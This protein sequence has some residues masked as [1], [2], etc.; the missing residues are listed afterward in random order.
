MRMAQTVERSLKQA[1]CDFDIVAHP[2]SATSLESARVASVPAERVAK[3]VILDDR[4]GN[5]IMAVLPA[6][7]HL[8]LSK[9]QS[10]GNWQLTRESGLPHLFG[11]CERGAIPALGEAYGMKMLLDPTLTRQGDIYLEAGNH[12][13]LVHM[14]M[15]EYLKLVPHAEVREVCH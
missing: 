9:I 13:Y 6:N 14:K 8:D 4:H 11:D 15:D 1:R 12:S 3:S 5:Y 7:K 2:H 10:L